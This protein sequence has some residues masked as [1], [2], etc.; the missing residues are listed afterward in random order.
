[1]QHN[2][3]KRCRHNSIF[4]EKT[5]PTQDMVQI[6][7]AGSEKFVITQDMLQIYEDTM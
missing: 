6:I 4:Q 3:R 5:V 7:M 2:I 1:M